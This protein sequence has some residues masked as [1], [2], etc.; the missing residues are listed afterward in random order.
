MPNVVY[1]CQPCGLQIDPEAQAARFGRDEPVH[2]SGLDLQ[3]VRRNTKVA[4]SGQCER[5]YL[6]RGYRVEQRGRLIDLV[7]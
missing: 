3:V 7:P 1:V 6:A 4:H 5:Q 2:G